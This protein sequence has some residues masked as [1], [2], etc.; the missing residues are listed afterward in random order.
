MNF[1]AR[2]SR[3]RLDEVLGSGDDLRAYAHGRRPAS[4]MPGRFEIQAFR[5]RVVVAD[6][7]NDGRCRTVAE[8]WFPLWTITQSSPHPITQIPQAD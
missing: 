6:N 7:D 5:P 4:R 2:S 1:I 3:V 8:N